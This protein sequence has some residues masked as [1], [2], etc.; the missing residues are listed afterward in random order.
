MNLVGKI[1]TAL[2]A[3]FSVVFMAFALA[4]YATHK[5][6]REEVMKPDTGYQAQLK[7]EQDAKKELQAQYDR[8][9]AERDGERKTARD[10]AAALKTEADTLR[11]DNAEEEK[12]LTEVRE[13]ER[14][15][16]DAMKATQVT[17][18]ASRAE[19]EQV[20]KD[21]TD[22]LKQ[23]EDTFKKMVELTDQLHQTANELKALQ[24][25]NVTL[26]QDLQKYK[27]LALNLNISDPDAYVQKNAADFGDAKVT[28]I[29]GGGLIEISVGADAGV[30]KGHRLEVYRVGAAGPTYLG[31]VEVVETVPNRAVCKIIPEY[32]KGII[33]KGDNVAAKL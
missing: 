16:V 14:K 31:R 5:N 33:Q 17:A 25:R 21:R 1:L 26:V 15:A 8:L 6:W 3:L 18:S 12:K 29:S 20:R 11:R 30:H 24:A 9:I 13:G 19:L 4:V 27:D 10:M 22:A 23:K 2:I 32:Q 7:K 28:T